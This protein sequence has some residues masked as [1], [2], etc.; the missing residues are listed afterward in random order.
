MLRKKL[1]VGLLIIG[2]I[3]AFSIGFILLRQASSNQIIIRGVRLTVDLAKTPSEWEQGLSGRAS[4]PED[5]GML[6]VFDRESPWGFW[7]KDM[8]FPLDIIWFDS[9]RRVVHIEQDLPPCS[10]QGCPVYVPLANA[11]YVLEVN[12]G[13]VEAHGINLGDTFQFG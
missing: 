13:F 2:I 12:A 11:L 1:L 4:M 10:P 8:R 7:M 9:S 6:F 5:R 3:S